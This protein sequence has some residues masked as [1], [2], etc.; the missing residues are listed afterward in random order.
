MSFNLSFGR[1]IAVSGNAGKIKK[2]NKRLL[3]NANNGDVIMK[4]V[5]SHY[6][7][8]RL[9]GA[10]AQA[11]KNGDSVEIYITGD[12]VKNVR[13]K[14]KNWD[15]LDGILAHMD[16]YLQVGKITVGEVISKIIS[17]YKQN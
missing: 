7:N 13:Q 4:D 9:S 8:A 16:S 11:V 3:P 10:L 12:D 5:T 1:V 6:K 15:T 17:S 14:Q 2:I